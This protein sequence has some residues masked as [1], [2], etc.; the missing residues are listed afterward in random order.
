MEVFGNW[1]PILFFLLFPLTLKCVA[2]Q[3]P[4]SKLI[5]VAPRLSE[6]LY[7]GGV[8][9]LLTLWIP[10]LSQGSIP[11]VPVTRGAACGQPNEVIGVMIGLVAMTA[12]CPKAQGLPEGLSEASGHEAV[13][14]RVSC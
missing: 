7:S 9:L 1:G 8:C 13:E 6:A 5:P 14:H 3:K 2:W 4:L 12:P 11:A 10:V